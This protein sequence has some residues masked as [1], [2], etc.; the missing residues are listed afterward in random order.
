MQVKNDS[1]EYQF[2]LENLRQY[3][4]EKY[5]EELLRL[6]DS[7]ET[8]SGLLD[9]INIFL[10]EHSWT[11]AHS[12]T[13][14]LAQRLYDDLIGF[15][16]LERYLYA[17]EIEEINGNA[18]DEI[19]IVA[20]GRY[21]RLE[22]RFQSPE[23]ARDIVRKMMRIGGI[24]LDD[25]RPWGDSFISTGIRI[26]AMIPPLVDE[27]A[28]VAFSIRKQRPKSW[29]KEDF[30]RMG[31]MNAEIFDFLSLCVNHGISL[32]IAGATS[33]GK[34]SL[35]SALLTQL[36]PDK[37]IF[38]IEDTRETSLAEHLEKRIIYTKTRES[39]AENRQVSA[40]DLLKAALRYH[41]DIIVPAEIRDEVALIAV[42]AGRTGHPILTGLHANSAKD[43]YSRILSLC[44]MGKTNLSEDLLMQMIVSA[45]P[46]MVFLTQMA[47]GKRRLSEIFEAYKYNVAEKNLEGR[48]IYRFRANKV[49]KD[50]R[51]KIVSID[52]DYI[53]ENTISPFLAHQLRMNGCE[54]EQIA[55][56]AAPGW[57]DES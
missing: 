5:A 24:I 6:L 4:K 40:S 16:F 29:S 49:Q 18:W 50:G 11:N 45:F 56:Y 46:V 13:G 22:E 17:D 10:R 7:A 9:L 48:M 25:K 8:R 3:L 2:L 15:S 38:V 31:T 12:I 39:E 32:G 42:E 57:D 36:N 47:D 51:G 34:T 55:F 35:I 44:M 21:Q 26:S 28:G 54:A 37:R 19:E 30:L 53:R 27:D 43:A 23:H 14:E 52:G 41:P 33:S 20:K 1:Q